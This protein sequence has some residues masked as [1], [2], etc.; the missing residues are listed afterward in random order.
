[1]R[2]DNSKTPQTIYL[3]D[4]TPASFLAQKTD[5][6]FQIFEDKTIVT[7]TVDYVINTAGKGQDL[8]LN[9]DH[10]TIIEVLLNGQTFSGYVVD[11]GKMTIANASSISNG[12][13]VLTIATEI[14]PTNNTALEGLYKSQG[15]Y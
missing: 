2:T 4:Y 1:M 9:G 5:L 3:K 6:R 7:S 13:F 14:D 11:D 15:N 12:K 10:Q 8:V